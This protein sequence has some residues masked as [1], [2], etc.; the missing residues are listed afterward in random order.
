MLLGDL[1]DM[2]GAGICLSFTFIISYCYLSLCLRRMAL[3]EALITA[4]G[5]Q[6]RSSSLLSTLTTALLS[7]FTPSEAI[8]SATKRSCSKALLL[9]SSISRE[10]Y[11][12]GLSEVSQSVSDLISLFTVVGTGVLD[13]HSNE[14]S[15]YPVT[16]AV[17]LF[18]KA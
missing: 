3:C 7:S 15:V 16:E 6:D 11:I 18:E 1:F 12:E 13:R 5:V 4:E 2:C 9:I 10:G 8:S 17:S 14:A